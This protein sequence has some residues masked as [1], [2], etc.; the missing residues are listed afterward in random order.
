MNSNVRKLGCLASSQ[1]T[2]SL[3]QLLRRELDEL[4]A[5]IQNIPKMVSEECHK[6]II[7]VESHRQIFAVQKTSISG[8]T[9]WIRRELSVL[10]DETHVFKFRAGIFFLGPSCPVGQLAFLI[11]RFFVAQ[12]IL[13]VAWVSN[14]HCQCME[15]CPFCNLVSSNRLHFHL[16]CPTCQTGCLGACDF[17]KP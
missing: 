15:C 10:A 11:F 6:V 8:K 2:F 7:Q 14:S 12:S 9:Y 5:T 17:F 16:S 1:I 4:R 3:L 13:V